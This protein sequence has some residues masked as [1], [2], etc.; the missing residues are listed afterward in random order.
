MLSLPDSRKVEVA[1]VLGYPKYRFQRCIPRRKMEIV[2]NSV[3][4]LP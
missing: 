2:W 1:L 4:T 3:K